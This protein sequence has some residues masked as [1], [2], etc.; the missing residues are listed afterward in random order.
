MERIIQSFKLMEHKNITFS[1]GITSVNSDRS[2]DVDS[3]VKEADAL[4]YDSKE[5]S[6]ADNGFHISLSDE[7]H[8]K[9]SSKDK[10]IA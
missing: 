10:K 8:F 5:K 1:A 6:K 4:M 2:F 7:T 9:I 3:L